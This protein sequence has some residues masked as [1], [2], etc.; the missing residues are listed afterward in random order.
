MYNILN[1][2]RLNEK[3]KNKRKTSFSL[4]PFLLPADL[5]N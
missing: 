1:I 4:I 5:F 2:S 3:M